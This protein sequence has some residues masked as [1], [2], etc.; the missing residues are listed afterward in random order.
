MCIEKSNWY[1]VGIEK[2]ILVVFPQI[3]FFKKNTSKRVHLG[4]YDISYVTVTITV[5]VPGRPFM[6]L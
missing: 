1:V 5:T 2:S 4:V 3:L 6:H